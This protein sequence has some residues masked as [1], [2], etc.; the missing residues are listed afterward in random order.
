MSE[1]S[2]ASLSSSTSGASKSNVKF[3]FDRIDDDMGKQRDG[4]VNDGKDYYSQSNLSLVIRN[5]LAC[6]QFHKSN[7][8]IAR[9]TTIID[10]LKLDKKDSVSSS[11][12]VSPVRRSAPIR[13]RPPHYRPRGSISSSSTDS[14]NVIENHRSIQIQDSPA[15]PPSSQPSSLSSLPSSEDAARKAKETLT[16]FAA[17]SRRK[18]SSSANSSLVISRI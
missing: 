1:D 8:S 10:A 18:A 3:K 9:G 16:T 5:R 4:Q 13:M 12:G 11:E 17:A 7:A 14:A 15:S 2:D 6:N